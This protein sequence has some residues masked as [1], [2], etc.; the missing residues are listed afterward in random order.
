MVTRARLRVP[1]SDQR[2]VIIKYLPVTRIDIP[3]EAREKLQ[4]GRPASASTKKSG[5]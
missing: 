1:I 4:S 3:R 2:I 5:A